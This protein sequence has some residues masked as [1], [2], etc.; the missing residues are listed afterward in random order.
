MSELTANSSPAL[1]KDENENKDSP[2]SMKNEKIEI[3][4]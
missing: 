3:E 2:V 1:V 4:I